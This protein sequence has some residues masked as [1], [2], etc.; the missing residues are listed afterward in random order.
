MRLTETG[1]GSIQALLAASGLIR[2]LTGLR[3]TRPSYL[4][5]ARSLPDQANVSDRIGSCVQ[6]FV[7]NPTK[8]YLDLPKFTRAG[9][10]Y[11]LFLAC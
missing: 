4:P 1:L 3:H 7:A 11:A 10:R 6:W 9:L 5:R 8:V 2:R